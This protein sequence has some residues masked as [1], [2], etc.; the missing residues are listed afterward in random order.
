MGDCILVQVLVVHDGALAGIF[1]E[2]DLLNRVLAKGLNPDHYA[3][4][5]MMTPNP[6][7]VQSSMTILGAL[8]EV[9]KAWVGWFVLSGS[10]A[11]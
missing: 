8:Q 11:F 10:C 5:E 9:R 6:D 7:T 3:V 1:T 2:K 4:S